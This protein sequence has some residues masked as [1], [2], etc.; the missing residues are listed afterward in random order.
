MLW[1]F[2]NEPSSQFAAYIFI[3]LNLFIL[4]FKCRRLLARVH[5]IHSNLSDSAILFVSTIGQDYNHKQRSDEVW[6]EALKGLVMYSTASLFVQHQILVTRPFHWYTE[7]WQKSEK[8]N[9]NTEQSNML[10][11]KQK[12]FITTTIPS[13]TKTCRCTMLQRKK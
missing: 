7:K 8:S 13:W 9:S 11:E 4:S 2:S 12:R 10:E 1:H 6:I 3:S 5:N